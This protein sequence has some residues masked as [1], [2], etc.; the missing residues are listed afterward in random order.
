MLVSSHV[1]HD[2]VQDDPTLVLQAVKH[3][4]DHATLAAKLPSNEA[5]AADGPRD[6]EPPQQKRGREDCKFN[7]TTK[8]NRTE[9]W[10]AAA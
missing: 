1:G 7:K 4:L 3:V 5:L 9:K 8:V 6:H 10:K 2:V